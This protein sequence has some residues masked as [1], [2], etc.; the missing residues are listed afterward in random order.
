MCVF[1]VRL[2]CARFF[3]GWGGGR[4]SL[5]KGK[6]RMC[7]ACVPGRVCFCLTASFPLHKQ[8]SSHIPPF[9][10]PRLLLLLTPQTKTVSYA[11]RKRRS[12][13]M[14][15]PRPYSQQRTRHGREKVGAGAERTAAARPWGPGLACASVR[16]FESSQTAARANARPAHPNP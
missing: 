12:R 8:P 14:C 10:L 3:R 4:V 11:P 9:L 2:G 1:L 7:E 5:K 15:V 16:A 13:A 6:W